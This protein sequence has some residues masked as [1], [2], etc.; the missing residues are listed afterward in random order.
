MMGEPIPQSVPNG[1]TLYGP[2]SI[3][4]PIFCLC[5]WMGSSSDFGFF[6]YFQVKPVSVFS[7]IIIGFE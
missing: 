7:S 2:L 1:T 4:C 5:T 3:F 6:G